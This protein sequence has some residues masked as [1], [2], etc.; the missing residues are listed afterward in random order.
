MYGRVFWWWGWRDSLDS[1]LSTLCELCVCTMLI[2]PSSE[3]GQTPR[4]KEEARCV[5]NT[6]FHFASAAQRDED[7]LKMLLMDF[8]IASIPPDSIR[9]HPR[10]NTEIQADLEDQ[11]QERRNL[12]GG[13]FYF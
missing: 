11:V 1:R 9:I 4:S 7:V 8:C 12:E 10:D 5:S 6:D 13:M 3:K 2:T